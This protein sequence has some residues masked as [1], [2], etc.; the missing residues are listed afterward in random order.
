MSTHADHL[1]LLEAVCALAGRAGE[2]ILAVYAREDFEVACK[3]DDSPLTA[4]DLASHRLIVA[5]L[6]ELTPEIPVLSEES[7]A[8]AW[9]TRRRWSRYWL[10]DPL[11]GT[12]E[13]VK[14]NGEFT[15]NIAL[16]DG[17]RSV[18]GVVLAP[19]TGEL[20]FASVDAGAHMR[21]GGRTTPLRTRAAAA[22]PVVAGSRSH[23]SGRQA[24]LLA[25]IGDYTTL[26]MGSSLKFCLIA[27]GVADLYLRAGPT[28]EWDTAAAQ[29]VLEQAG[30]AVTR[31][32]GTALAYN[33]KDSLLNP[34]FLAVGDPSRDWPAR[35]ADVPVE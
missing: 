10:V 7:T 35:L 29:C 32:D 4:A 19:V 12:R 22:P 23:G 1:P 11:D 30:G 16:V 17:H 13:F 6:R 28:S 27:R 25:G 14:R 24:A 5:G 2:A 20:Y 18:M 9:E 3:S 15:V 34:E 31:L 33:T 26:A 21:R 8:I